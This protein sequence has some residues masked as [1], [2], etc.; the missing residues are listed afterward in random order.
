M[1]SMIDYL[2][3]RVD[4]VPKSTHLHTIPERVFTSMAIGT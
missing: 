2:Q 3:E 1:T 4:F